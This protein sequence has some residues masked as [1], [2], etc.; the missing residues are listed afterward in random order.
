[1]RYGAAAR[2]ANGDAAATPSQRQANADADAERGI[3]RP[4]R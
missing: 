2:A 3:A 4:Q 1:M